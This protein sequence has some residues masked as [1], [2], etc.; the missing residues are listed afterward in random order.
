MLQVFF[1]NYLSRL[2][3]LP[4]DAVLQSVPFKFFIKKSSKIVLRY[5]INHKIYIETQNDVTYF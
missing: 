2:R 4:S 3:S 5:R 1:M